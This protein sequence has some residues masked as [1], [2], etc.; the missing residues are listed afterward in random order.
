[1]PIIGA[2]FFAYLKS[3]RLSLI[4]DSMLRQVLST[5]LVRLSSV[6]YSLFLDPSRYWFSLTAVTSLVF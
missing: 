2:T 3:V 5:V 4:D 1:M 6:V